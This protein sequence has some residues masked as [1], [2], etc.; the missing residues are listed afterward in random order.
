MGGGIIRVGVVRAIVMDMIG[1]VMF[2]CK[3]RALEVVLAVAV[4]LGAVEVWRRMRVGAVEV[5]VVDARHVPVWGWD[6]GVGVCGT[7]WLGLL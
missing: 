2:V 1:A 3:V 5:W 6:A 7:A 4:G